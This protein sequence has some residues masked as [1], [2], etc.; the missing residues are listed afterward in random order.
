[1][2][3][4]NSHPPEWE[5]PVRHWYVDLVLRE[6]ARHAKIGDLEIFLISNQDVTTGKITV[7]HPK[8]REKLLQLKLIINAARKFIFHYQS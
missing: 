6:V 5:E 8:P 3:R 4:L 1:M 2:Y 7:D